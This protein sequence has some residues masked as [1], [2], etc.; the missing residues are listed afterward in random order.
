ML[1]EAQAERGAPMQLVVVEQQVRAQEGLEALEPL[2]PSAVVMVVVAAGLIAEGTEALAVLEVFQVVVVEVAEEAVLET[3]VVPEPMEQTAK[4]ESGPT[5][6]WTN[7][8]KPSRPVR[9]CCTEGRL[10]AICYRWLYYM[11]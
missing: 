11:D 7:S 9:S 2:M 4:L 6:E 8:K 5:D 3:Q 1:L 10:P